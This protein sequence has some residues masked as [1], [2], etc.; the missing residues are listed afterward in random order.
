MK[1]RAALIALALLLPGQAIAA[2]LCA[3]LKEVLPIAKQDRQMMVLRSGPELEFGER[4]ATRQVDGFRCV[5][6]PDEPNG[7]TYFNCTA[8]D[9]AIS[10]PTIAA[11][12]QCF[13]IE[14]Q[15]ETKS[16]A[17]TNTFQLQS[18]PHIWIATNEFTSGRF[19]FSLIT[20]G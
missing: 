10:K 7:R 16:Y 1:S 12:G 2:P 8:S 14:P 3:T 15:L 11:I 20:G 13:G 6:S 5:I 9:D 18:T 4:L 17:T 19:S